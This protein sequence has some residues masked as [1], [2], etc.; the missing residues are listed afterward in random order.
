MGAMN[1]KDT[2]Q[3]MWSN[4]FALWMPYCFVKLKAE[5]LSRPHIFLPLNRFHRP[6]N[7]DGP[8]LDEPPGDF[9]KYR[10][11]AVAFKRDPLSIEGV[12]L[13]RSKDEGYL[14]DNIN[15]DQTEFNASYFPRLAKLMSFA[16]LAPVK[17]VNRAA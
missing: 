15:F 14:Y 16:D 11:Q 9:E 3:V 8:W 17:Q 10:E 5:S 1:S 12:W 7:T 6:L 2:E 13:S 4:W